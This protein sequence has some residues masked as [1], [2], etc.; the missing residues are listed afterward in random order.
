[1]NNLY[2]TAQFLL[3]TPDL[4]SA[5]PDEG[6]EVA[7][8]GRSN[9]GKSSA[10]NAITSQKA[11]ARTSKTPGRTQQLVFFNLDDERRL[12]D[13]PGYGYAKVSLKMQKNWQL[14]MQRYLNERTALRGLFLLMDI[15][16]PL[17]PFDEQMIAWTQSRQLPLHIALTKADKLS[18]GNAKSTLL[19]TRDQ[20]EKQG[21]P[22]SLQ[23][24]SVPGKIG[25]DDAHEI[26]DEWLVVRK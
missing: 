9:A 16:R 23:L 22:C 10:I 14:N 6:L 7:F 19:S 17:T 2:R 12:V 5:P 24:F 25:V 21:V 18:R 20:L 8:A 26:L 3:S 11:L 15:R 4:K 13:L 1:M